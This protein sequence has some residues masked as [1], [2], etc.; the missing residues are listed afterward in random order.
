MVEEIVCKHFIKDL[1]DLSNDRVVNI[2]IVLAESFKNLHAKYEEIEQEAE[3]YSKA[4]QQGKT[5]RS[6]EKWC[7]DGFNYIKEKL[8]DY[9]NNQ[10]F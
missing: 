9:M 2:R 4:L 5:L 7:I 6:N 8:F 1:L 3:K 10:F